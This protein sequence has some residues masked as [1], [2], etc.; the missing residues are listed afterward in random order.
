MSSFEE[1]GLILLSL[2]LRLLDPALHLLC[3]IHVGMY[4]ARAQRAI[5]RKLQGSVFSCKESPLEKQDR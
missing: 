5:E 3:I 2:A 1:L 4:V